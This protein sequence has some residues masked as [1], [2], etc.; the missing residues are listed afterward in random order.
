M[1]GGGDNGGG[2]GGGRNNNGRNNS[3]NASANTSSE[4][5]VRSLRAAKA[6]KLRSSGQDPYAYSFQRSHTAAEL[7]ERYESLPAGKAAPG[8]EEQPVSV[9]GR[10]LARRVMGKLAFL[11]LADDS[12]EVQLYVDRSA[13]DER[14]E[15]SFAEV[16]SLVDVGDIVGCAGGVRRTEKGELSIAAHS[17]TVLTKA[18][19]PLPDK[20]HGLADV[21]KRYRQ[22]YVDMIATPGVRHALRARAL[23]TST[24]RRSLERRGFLEVETPV[25]EASAGGADARPFTTYHNALAQP[26]ALRIATELHLKRLVVGGF[27]RVFEI[28]RIFRNE[29]I[30]ARH[31]PEFTSV[32]LYQVFADYSDMMELTEELIR[33]AA[34]AVTGGTTLQYQGTEIDVGR[35]FARRTMAELVQAA[36][37]ALDAPALLER[38]ASSA[39]GADTASSSSSSSSSDGVDASSRAAAAAALAAAGCSRAAVAAALS[40]STPSGNLLNLLFEELVESSLI[41]PTFVLDHPAVVSPLAKPHRRTKGAAERFELFVAGRELANAYSE[42][43]DPLEQRRRLEAQMAAHS[44]ARE[45]RKQSRGGEAEEDGD[46]ENDYDVSLDEDFLLAL[47]HGMPPTGGMGMGLDRL[48]MLLVDAAS[49]RDVIAF[50]LLKRHQAKQEKQQEKGGDKEE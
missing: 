14:R 42:M 37:P 23:M 5:E 44:A 31:N 7:L 1:G 50:P 19:R 24:L 3:N 29:G 45:Q 17:L 34:V 4:A 25:L 33:E 41:Q 26:F 12:G 22:R 39:D 48:A 43:T 49:I 27:E 15:G 46:N 18:L 8:T 47:E 6:E 35:P 2:G 32:E 40:P 21:E 11:K 20:W 16:K 13:L 28:G 30:S 10:V 9:A 38:S 36:V